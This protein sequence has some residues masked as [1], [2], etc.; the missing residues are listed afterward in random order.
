M[1]EVK[2]MTETCANNVNQNLLMGNA[3]MLVIDKLPELPIFC[4]SA[5]LPSI[6]LGEAI[7]P[8]SVLDYSS[9]GEKLTFDPLIVSFP[10]NESLSNYLEIQNWMFRIADPEDV[11]K[12]VTEIRDIF[13]DGKLMM[14][15]SENKAIA[16]FT[17]KNIFPTNLS[18]INLDITQTPNPIIVTCTFKLS[19]FYLEP[20]ISA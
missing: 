8:T 7:I 4:Q 11:S 3:F 20:P 13:S 12:R 19:H 14:L 6:S 16:T 18:E 17:F 2:P 10:V 5:L 15:N 1:V 9:A